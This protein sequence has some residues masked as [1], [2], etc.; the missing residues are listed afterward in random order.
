MNLAMYEKWIWIELIG[1]DNTQ[2][3]FAVP[4]Y[5]ERIGFVPT[6]MSLLFFTPDFVHAHEGMESEA[7]LPI[8]V[9][10]Y[11]ARPYGKERNRQ[12]WT[13]YQLR[14]LVAEL[15]K[16]GAQIYCSFFDLFRVE[17][18]E[19]PRASEWCGAHPELYEM[20]KSGK[21]LSVIN[22]LRR[23]KDGTYY[24][25]F[26]IRD[27]MV[28][29]QDYGFDGYHGAD[30]YT[31]PRK[32]LAEADYSDDMVEQFA[33]FSGLAAEKELLEACDDNP[34][35]MGKRAEW[36][37][38]HKR[39]EWI[40]FHGARWAQLWHKIMAALRQEGK[41]AFINTAWTRDP[42]EALYRYGVDY[43]QLA[44]TGVDGFIVESVGASL[45][46]GADETEY[47]PC[48]EFM[49]MLMTI[50]AY[51][52]DTKLICLNAIQDTNEQW[53]ALSHAPTVLERDI[54]AFSNMYVQDQTGLRRCASG[55]MACLGDGISED[56]WKWIV[57]RWNLGFDSL[58]QRVVG[59][60]LV[61]SDEALHNSLEAYIASREWPA[62]KFTH[63]W[64]SRGAPI[65]AVVN[66]KDL[67]QATGPIIVANLH[68]LPDDQLEQVLTYRNGAAVMIGRWTE[69]VSKAAAGA[70]LSLE[71]EANQLFCAVRNE[72]GEC[73]E[74]FLMEQAKELVIEE[75]K[76]LS[77]I[78]DGLTWLDSL[79]YSPV[80][81]EFLNHC[82]QAL[83][84]ITGAPRMLRNEN[85]I[86]TAVLEMNPGRWRIIIRNLHMNYKTAHIDVGRSIETMSILTDFPG[87]PVDANDSKFKLYVP[88]RGMVIV[89]LDFKAAD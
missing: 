22:P 54:Y 46:A 27:L 14:G 73:A 68:T 51:V 62:H 71:C 58:A 55:F 40:Q 42:F 6:A 13:N 2:S 69:R 77:E 65:H 37:W 85:H 26:F 83:I 61:W 23:F 29:M 19:T 16:H 52:P 10:S 86:R 36:I 38:H 7:I 63:E 18:G 49:S 57:K 80:A 39:M 56:G 79:Y 34:A 28:V 31:S 30:G 84:E 1:F 47:E 11:A 89:E 88:G 48:T 35:N 75:Q 25:D 76:S 33:Q 78:N 72:H 4:A 8:E 21:A 41:K 53:D 87:I 82:V 17:G 66:V 20:N 12:V 45:S 3:D 59:A 24:E 44:A 64:I 70:G 74:V 15:Q 50:K 32:S 5:M 9:C 60:S 81:E 67:Q 43:Q